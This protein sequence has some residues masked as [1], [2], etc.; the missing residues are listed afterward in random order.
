MIKII[1]RLAQGSNA[2]IRSPF[3]RFPVVALPLVLGLA[4]CISSSNP[5]PPES[6]TTIVV[7]NGSTV[8]CTNGMAPPCP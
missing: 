5:S 3:W 4:G 7:P 1:G 2:P 6:H 8:T